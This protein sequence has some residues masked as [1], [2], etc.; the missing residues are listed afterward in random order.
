M[1][2]DICTKQNLDLKRKKK[3]ENCKLLPKT[4]IT[5]EHGWWEDAISYWHNPFSG[6]EFIHFSGGL[7][8]PSTQRSSILW[9]SC[10]GFSKCFPLWSNTNVHVSHA[11]PMQKIHQQEITLILY[12][13]TLSPS[14]GFQ[15]PPGSDC[16]CV[17]AYTT[18]LQ[19][20]HQEK[21]ATDWTETIIRW[22]HHIKS[23]RS[24]F[25]SREQDAK[26][27]MV[28]P[29]IFRRIID[30]QSPC[31]K[32]LEA[33]SVDRYIFNWHSVDW[34]GKGLEMF[35]E[36][37]VRDHDVLAPLGS[38]DCQDGQTCFDKLSDVSIQSNSWL[39]VP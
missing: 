21:T 26:W 36:N 6:D 35:G 28:F 25:L 5:P 31:R 1:N 37:K 23:T 3:V 19:V 7:I 22:S 15:I 17:W 20:K 14:L 34:K 27:S 24:R 39:V 16:D 8:L 9:G 4:N 10:Q 38:F 32:Q 11:Y 2:D 29:K 12:V 33:F 30:L 18:V 13:Y